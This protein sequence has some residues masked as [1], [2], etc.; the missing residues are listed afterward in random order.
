MKTDVRFEDAKPTVTHR[1]LAT[2]VDAGLVK[3]VISQNV[4]GLHL[5]SNLPRSRL[6]ELHGNMFME[7]C[8]KCGKEYVR[9][10]AVPTVGRKKTGNVCIG[11]G[12]RGRCRG[13]LRDS[14]L[15][16]EDPLPKLDLERADHHSRC[17]DLALCLG[18]TLQII[19]SG[20]LP[21]LTKKNGGKLV[22]CNLQPTKYDEEAD[23]V[24]HGYVDE[25]MEVLMAKLELP[26][27]HS[28]LADL[29]TPPFSDSTD[30][31]APR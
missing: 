28:T 6:S 22:I 10:T 27:S 9:E 7:I 1:A 20:T 29:K 5:K 26:L 16:W 30:G 19:P 25:V 13:K 24:I 2:L 3:Y 21:L 15:D 11:G 18:T 14:V 12:S 17:A 31:G 23:L 8:D 4:D